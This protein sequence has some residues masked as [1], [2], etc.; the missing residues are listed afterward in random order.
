MHVTKLCFAC[1]MG[2]SPKVCFVHLMEKQPFVRNDQCRSHLCFRP[3]MPFSSFSPTRNALSSQTGLQLLGWK[4]LPTSS[5][6]VPLAEILLLNRSNS[7]AIGSEGI[8]WFGASL[9]QWFYSS[10]DL[11]CQAIEFQPL[12]GRRA[13]HTQFEESFFVHRPQCIYP[14]RYFELLKAAHSNNSYC[15]WHFLLLHQSTLK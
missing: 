6:G 13:S 14:C 1:L 11:L 8:W 7:R 15:S 10:F 4:I 9:I 2:K 3:A 12:Y 5:F